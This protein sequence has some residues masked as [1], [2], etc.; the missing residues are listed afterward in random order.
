[1]AK[2]KVST[3]SR[4]YRVF[5]TVPGNKDSVKSYVKFYPSAEAAAQDQNE[6]LEPEVFESHKVTK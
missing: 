4:F 2:S 1:M 3:E 5:K 6:R